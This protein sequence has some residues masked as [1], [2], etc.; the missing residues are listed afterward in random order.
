MLDN[1]YLGVIAGRI[2]SV[3]GT[4]DPDS[5]RI[6]QAGFDEGLE[7]GATLA[8]RGVNRGQ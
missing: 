1:N 2:G 7:V 6:G 5:G 3:G 8:I 4:L